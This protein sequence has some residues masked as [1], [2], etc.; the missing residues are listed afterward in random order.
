MDLGK[1]VFA[2]FAAIALAIVAVSYSH[3]VDAQ[4]AGSG[5]SISAGGNQSAWAIDSRGQILFCYAPSL[6]DASC[7]KVK[8]PT[9]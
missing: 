2:G 5:F 4:S 3:R 8:M 6:A 9:P 7:A 1:A